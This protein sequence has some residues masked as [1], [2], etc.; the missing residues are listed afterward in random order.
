MKY[1]YVDLVSWHFPAVQGTPGGVCK[2]AFSC[3][4]WHWES[5]LDA[6]PRGSMRYRAQTWDHITFKISSPF[7]LI[8]VNEWERGSGGRELDFGQICL[9]RIFALRLI[10]ALKLNLY[11]KMMLQLKSCFLTSSLQISTGWKVW[12]LNS[13]CVAIKFC[14]ERSVNYTMK[15]ACRNKPSPSSISLSKRLQKA[16]DPAGAR[17]QAPCSVASVSVAADLAA[18]MASDDHVQAVK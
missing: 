18:S 13:D 8:F 2:C 16:V 1:T 5:C 12:K 10:F 6:A 9:R 7:S 14:W 11:K 4:P 17:L 15:V 3:Y